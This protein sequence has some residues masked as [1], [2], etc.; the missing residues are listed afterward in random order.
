MLTGLTATLERVNI[1][2]LF[3]SSNDQHQRTYFLNL[4]FLCPSN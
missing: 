4:T 1:H 3:T 2:N